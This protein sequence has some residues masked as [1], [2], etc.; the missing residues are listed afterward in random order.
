MASGGRPE[1][2]GRGS[3][4]AS[5]VTQV[6]DAAAPGTAPHV[7]VPAANVKVTPM[8]LAETAHAEAPPPADPLLGVLVAGR[9][10]IQRM[11]GQGGMG[12]VYEV[13]HTTI[14]KRFAVKLVQ[15]LHAGRTEVAQRF[16]REAKAAGSIDSDYVAQVVDVGQDEQLGLFMLMELLVGDDLERVLEHEKRLDPFAACCLAYQAATGLA[17]AHRAGVIHRDLK[18]ANMFLARRDD[19]SVIVKLLDFGIAKLVD[20]AEQSQRGGLTRVG[21]A[22][23]TAQYMA[24]EQAQGASDLDQR[25]DVYALGA[26]L[27]EMIAGEPLIPLLPTY[28]QM[29]VKVVTRTGPPSLQGLADLPPG[30]E[31]LVADMVAPL[32]GERLPTMGAVIGRLS[33]IYPQVSDAKVRIGPVGPG[34]G[35]FAEIIPSVSTTPHESRPSHP[36]TV[37]SG[38]TSAGVFYET[39][40]DDNAAVGDTSRART[41]R[42]IALGVLSLVVVLG[43]VAVYRALTQRGS[44]RPVQAASG[45]VVLPSPSAAAATPGNAATAPSG[46]S[47]LVAPAASTGA[48]ASA[49]P[50]PVA[51]RKPGQPQNVGRAPAWHPAWHPAAKRSPRPRPVAAKKSAPVDKPAPTNKPAPA[52]KPS[53]APAATT[54][55]G[56]AGIASHF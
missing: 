47:I 17:K 41:T 39:P 52:N 25:A 45:L 24:P 54:Q 48:S 38:K 6:I 32:P 21:A 9:Y 27:Y 1:G 26:V 37:V 36:A 7:A 30:L 44:A 20:E 33:A 34:R 43:G 55:V 16:M 51:S 19:G 23:G 40:P 56:G 11:I 12:A 42:A 49:A 18:P 10:R 22:I 2:G 35:S 53:P 8:E 28:E 46:A 5:K 14:G 29:I 4:A 31:Q 15:R 13:E 50:A 3:G